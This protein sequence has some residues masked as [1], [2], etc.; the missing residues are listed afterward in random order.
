MNRYLVQ[1]YYKIEKMW[2]D[3]YA[4]ATITEAVNYFL[5]AREEYPETEFRIVIIVEVE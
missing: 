3:E 4:F 5:N 1:T 2:V